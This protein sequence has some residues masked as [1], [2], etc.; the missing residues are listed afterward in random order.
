MAP[1]LAL[2]TQQGIG[3]A[4]VVALLLGWLAY[5]VTTVRRREEPPGAEVELAPNRKPYYDDE[6]LET[7]KLDRS[8]LW[9]LVLLVVVGRGRPVYWLRAPSRQAGA[10]QGF[11]QRSISR[12]ASLFQPTDSPEPGAHFG[13]G[14]CHGSNGQGGVV[15]YT[16]D[17]DGSAGP[18]KPRIV[19]WQAPAVDTALLRFS[20]D[21]V[22]KILVYGRANS[23]M[24][25][26]GVEGG[27]PMNAQQIDDLV[28]YLDSIKVDPEEA[29]RSAVEKWGQT[30]GE[31]LFN[32]NCPRCHTKGWSY[33]EPDVPAGGAYGP[34]LRD[35]ATLR[36]F[37]LREDHIE[38]ITVGAE[39]A[40]EYG[41]RGVGDDAG[42]GMPG[43]GAQ[44]TP[45]QIEAIVDYERGLGDAG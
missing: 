15:R 30:D 43:F 38:F 21:E 32:N 10:A 4:V 39:Y 45:E 14:T 37:P 18:M 5:I 16:L 22:R 12:G 41:V 6:T 3:V 13:C 9:A 42:G 40:E 1:F 23:P 7:K 26:W 27:G 33:G 11:D 19:Q 31:L 28:N 29:K 8:L 44:L 24:P 35:G 17:E 2:T 25:A 34:N 20:R 36:Q